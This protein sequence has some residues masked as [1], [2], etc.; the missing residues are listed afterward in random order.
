MQ[1]LQPEGWARGPLS[2][3]LHE[4]F[5]FQ[6]SSRLIGADDGPGGEIFPLSNWVCSNQNNF[7]WLNWC[8]WFCC[9]WYNQSSEMFPENSLQRYSITWSA[10]LY[11]AC[12]PHG[13]VFGD[14]FFHHMK[15]YLIKVIC[16]MSL[17]EFSSSPLIKREKAQ[18]N[19]RP[20]RFLLTL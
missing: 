11:T 3:V 18:T 17:W 16:Q 20:P 15:H 2:Y 14:Q 19:H 8:F 10:H 5:Q 7:A 12:K 4:A 6:I 9:H 1:G 13:E